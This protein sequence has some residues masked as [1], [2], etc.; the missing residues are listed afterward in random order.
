MIMSSIST[1]SL[2]EEGPHPTPVD[3][4]TTISSISSSPSVPPPS[5]SVPSSS[6]SPSPPSPSVPS[7]SS[8]A[9]PEDRVV[10]YFSDLLYKEAHNRIFD[11]NSTMFGESCPP[12]M[13]KD[14][15]FNGDKSVSATNYVTPIIMYSERTIDRP[16]PVDDREPIAELP[17]SFSLALQYINGT[18]VMG[19][20]FR[21]A[22]GPDYP[23]MVQSVVSYLGELI[24][25]RSSWD[26]TWVIARYYSL[27]ALFDEHYDPLHLGPWIESSVYTPPPFD[28]SFCT[29]SYEDFPKWVNGTLK[30]NAIGFT[31][32][33]RPLIVPLDDW[34][35]S[36][37]MAALMCWHETDNVPVRVY[38][39]GRQARHPSYSSFRSNSRSPN[40]HVTTT[41]T[42]PLPP[43]T[44][45]Q[46]SSDPLF[47]DDPDEPDTPDPDSEPATPLPF[48]RPPLDRTTGLPK[49]VVPNKHGNFYERRAYFLEQ[50]KNAKD[51]LA[52]VEAH[53]KV[54]PQELSDAKRT[55]AL[56][57]VLKFTG[58]YPTSD[59]GDFEI[60]VPFDPHGSEFRPKT[61]G[62]FLPQERAEV[63]QATTWVPASLNGSADYPIYV[64]FVVNHSPDATD[65]FHVDDP[66]PNTMSYPTTKS[67]YQSYG[68]FLRANIPDADQWV[69][70]AIFASRSF[71]L[72][73]QDNLMQVTR[74]PV[75]QRVY[76]TPPQPYTFIAQ[77][78][79]V[80][81]ASYSM[82]TPADPTHWM[83]A[84]CRTQWFMQEY[85]GHAFGIS[86][87]SLLAGPKRDATIASDVVIP[88]HQIQSRIEK[89][90]GYF[91][92]DSLRWPLEQD[93]AV[94]VPIHSPLKWWEDAG[95]DVAGPFP[96]LIPFP[97]ES[98]TNTLPYVFAPVDWDP[99]LMWLT[100]TALLGQN[101]DIENIKPYFSGAGSV[102]PRY[103]YA[104]PTDTYGY[105]DQSLDPQLA[106]FWQCAFFMDFSPNN[107]L[108]NTIAL[109]GRGDLWLRLN[110]TGH[111]LEGFKFLTKP[112]PPA[113]FVNRSFRP[114]P[115]L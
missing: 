26:W 78:V 45:A 33:Y 24:Y 6:S 48:R 64:L 84:L 35:P 30:S 5:T 73:E 105:I 80:T 22:G 70:A 54:S 52:R 61:T 29:I 110:S 37:A 97:G 3:P 86:R 60:R 15:T 20:G 49:D 72:V 9:S 7:S 17:A 107:Q 58:S 76:Y 87:V 85:L 39:P 59:A 14:A 31:R 63:R 42:V 25:R 113:M 2:K 62:T 104:I 47:G 82:P 51:T 94:F 1:S 12:I 8:T 32:R 71:S 36:Q 53:Q 10:S 106:P 44:A 91:T 4:I 27:I 28:F 38:D 98:G 77:H 108:S 101:R 93:L 114:K 66:I 115:R 19:S 109:I 111:A 102:V 11:L 69:R 90:F 92:H 41:T 57:E 74:W 56:A 75:V 34:I 89:N 79:G 21:H 67:S 16:V 112:Q 83:A 40:T 103:Y 81:P 100:A 18:N 46:P 99:S 68:D 13:G 55:M 96:Q 50:Y 23:L 88:L 43:D 65:I 95:K